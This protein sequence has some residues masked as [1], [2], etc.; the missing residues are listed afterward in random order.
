M[1]IFKHNILLHCASVGRLAERHSDGCGWFN[2]LH[3][4]YWMHKSLI[5]GILV[6]ASLL[7]AIVHAQQNPAGLALPNTAKIDDKFSPL[8]PDE[9]RLTGGMLGT[10]IEANK[11]HRMLVVDENDMLDCFEHRNAPH[12]DWQGEHIGKF[13]HAATLVW[14]NT[15]D[16]T[17]KTKLD[18][19][20]TRLLKTQEP[21]GYLGTYPENKRWTSWD[22]W[23]HKYALIGLLTYYQYTNQITNDTANISAN[24]KQERPLTRPTPTV[25][26]LA[27]QSPAPADVLNACRKIGNLLVRTFGDGP[28][29]RDINKSGAHVGMA[30]DSVLEAIVLLYRATSDPRY[31]Q[32]ANYI[33]SHYDAPGGP[34][35]LA[36]LEKTHSVRKV[37]NAKAYEMTSN[38]NGILELYRVT[39]NKRYLDDMLT[40]WKDIVANRL[41]ITGSGSSYET[42][43][44]DFHLPNAQ[45]YNICET[46]VTVTWEQMNLELLRLTGE[47]RFADQLERTIYNHL[48]GA[49]K[50]TGD[51]WSYYTPLEGR[52]PYDNFTT[53]CHSS[54]PR[55]IALIPELAMMTSADGG[56][57]VNLYN[58]GTATVVIKHKTDFPGTPG[59]VPGKLTVQDKIT[60]T[61]ETQYPLDGRVKLTVTSEARN[62]KFPLRLRIPAWSAVQSLTV[63]GKPQHLEPTAAIAQYLVLERTWKKGDTVEFVLAMPTKLILGSHDDE[64][65]AAIMY[66]PLVLTLDALLNPNAPINKI[67]LATDNPTNFALLPTTQTRSYPYPVFTVAGHIAGQ[68]QT[69]NLLLRP[70]ADAGSDGKSRY[71]VWIPLPGHAQAGSNSAFSGGRMSASR[72]GNVFDSICDDDT[73]TFAVTYDM[74]KSDTDW[75]AVTLDKPVIINTVLFAHG[76]TFHNGGWFDASAGKPQIQVQTEVGGGWKT[77]ATL[78]TYP[79]TTAADAGGLQAG[80][81]FT[82]TFQPVR[83]LAIR[84]LGRPAGGDNPMQ[85]FASCSELQAFNK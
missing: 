5:A 81:T 40:A 32:F 9:I 37:A 63:N 38:F 20:V 49:Q 16:P 67:E 28:G 42:Y 83:A 62:I 79:N 11:Q 60:L 50:P 74:Q 55:G 29:Q 15:H 46:C 59:I 3:P 69:T 36:S 7:P 85:A 68:T 41:Y 26:L 61:E 80:Q 45:K 25:P 82:A 17:L 22:V 6:S 57:V 48:L 76:K 21:D 56:L 72:T 71:E 84:V 64:G 4:V 54:G 78:S 73:S 1:T 35:I 34:A 19:V 58:A 18:R 33:V 14:Q 66:G 27:V 44:D 10:R 65:K 43:Q 24:G 77:V 47:P 12:Q 70:Y 23:C 51:D 13:L 75:F 53:C 2:R 8:L 52:K 31:E 30:P 39:G